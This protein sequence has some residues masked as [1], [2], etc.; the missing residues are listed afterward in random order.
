MRFVVRSVRRCVPA[1]AFE[2]AVLA[3]CAPGEVKEVGDACEESDDCAPGLECV[4][5]DDK[6]PACLPAPTTRAPKDEA[7]V[8]DGQ[9]NL[10][11]TN[12]WPVEARCD[13]DRGVCFCSADAR[14]CGDGK[15]LSSD[16]LCVGEPG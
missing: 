1:L 12:L 16:C 15:T 14:D 13:R 7:C 5:F 6:K 11:S 2:L 9:C 3:A 10:G 4:R 8:L